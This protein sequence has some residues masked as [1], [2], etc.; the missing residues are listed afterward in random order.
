MGHIHAAAT[1]KSLQRIQNYLDRLAVAQGYH[2]ECIHAF[3]GK[4]GEE[5]P[6]LVADLKA[7]L[8]QVMTT[9]SNIDAKDAAGH[10]TPE[11]VRRSGEESRRIQRIPL[12]GMRRMG[13]EPR[14]G[15]RDSG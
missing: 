6:L 10:G 13:R 12:A 7:L 3:I 11:L 4:D 1:A 5:I 8:Q 15:L 9:S 2:K 14:A